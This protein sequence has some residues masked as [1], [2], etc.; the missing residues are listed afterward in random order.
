METKMRGLYNQD[1]SQA[2][3]DVGERIERLTNRMAEA[4]YYDDLRFEHAQRMA[5]ALLAK[6]EEYRGAEEASG[7]DL[8][9]LLNAMSWPLMTLEGKTRTALAILSGRVP[10]VESDTGG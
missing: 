9:M 2:R 10:E 6:L 7:G 5:E 3:L 1:G 8:L 4:T